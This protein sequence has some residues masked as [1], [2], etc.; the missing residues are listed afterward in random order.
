M[1]DF[2]KESK[3]ESER[4]R[5]MMVEL[6]NLIHRILHLSTVPFPVNDTLINENIKQIKKITDIECESI[7]NYLKKN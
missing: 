4:R 2:N 7:S 3:S 5:L 1:N 6:P